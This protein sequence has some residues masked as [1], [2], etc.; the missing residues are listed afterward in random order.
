MMQPVYWTTTNKLM[1]KRSSTAG[2]K[3][4]DTH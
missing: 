2:L 1:E 4:D 3:A